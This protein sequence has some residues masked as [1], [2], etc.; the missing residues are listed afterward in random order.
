MI[1][2]L[3]W[4]TMYDKKAHAGARGGASASANGARANVTEP[5]PATIAGDLEMALKAQAPTISGTK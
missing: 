1:D 2:T 5:S 3:Q 4:V